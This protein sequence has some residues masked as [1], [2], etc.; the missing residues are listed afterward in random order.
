MGG[1]VVFNGDVLVRSYDSLSLPAGKGTVGQQRVAS[2]WH[3]NTLIND[4]K[5]KGRAPEGTWP[6]DRFYPWWSVLL[7]FFLNL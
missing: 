6:D 4:I 2:V 7:I 3:V 5:Q 1:L